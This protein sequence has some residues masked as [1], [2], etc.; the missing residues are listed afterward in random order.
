MEV[1]YISAFNNI[2]GKSPQEVINEI[3]KK[4]NQRGYNSSY[5]PCKGVIEINEDTYIGMYVA[6]Y[7]QND[8]RIRQVTIRKILSKNT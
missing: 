6:K 1:F 4:L 3:C 5:L 2:L 7:S 8:I